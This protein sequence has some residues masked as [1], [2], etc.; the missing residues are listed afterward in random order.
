[1]TDRP[2]PIDRALIAALRQD[3]RLSVTDLAHR[4]GVSRTTARQHLQRLMDT[5]RIRRFTIE[6]DVDAEGQVR[7]ITLVQ[8]QGRMSRAVIR[9]L[10][11]IADVS[12]VYATNGNW[13]L[14]AEIHTDTLANFDRALR[15]IRE[16]PG[17]TN[18]ESCLLLA[19]VV[20]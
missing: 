17:V 6:T 13:D 20:E 11:R 5:G 3:A 10:H 1:M 9:A 18:S 2:D 16:I 19:P 14:V 15:E 8:L 12:T 7:A 4:L